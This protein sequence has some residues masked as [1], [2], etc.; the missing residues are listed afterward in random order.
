MAVGRRFSGK[1]PRLIGRVWNDVTRELEDFLKKLF[2]A[3]VGIPFGFMGTTP[4]TVEIEDSGSAGTQGSG[5]AAADHE[6][7][8]DIGTGTPNTV[9][10]WVTGPKL[11]D[12]LITDDGTVVT[13]NTTTTIRAA[14]LTDGSRGFFNVIGTL[15]SSPST[16][17]YGTRFII[18]PNATSSEVQ[19]GVGVTLNAG[20]TGSTEATIALAMG[21]AN[22]GTG[23]DY[24]NTANFAGL[25]QAVA[26][27]VGVNVG[28]S[29]RASGGSGNM[30]VQGIVNDDSECIGGMF[31]GRSSD[32]RSVG[33][34]AGLNSAIPDLSPLPNGAALIISNSDKAAPIIVARDNAN[35]VFEIDDG[36]NVRLDVTITPGGTTGNQTINKAAGSVNFA[37][38]AA[39]LT[40]TNNLI[41]AN[42]LIFLTLL[43]NDAT[44]V[45]G[46]VVAASGSCVIN[47]AVVPTAETKVGFLVINDA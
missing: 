39:T 4:T 14:A 42:S 2:D 8:V 5:W 31:L 27:T 28:L 3:Q 36:G 32:S 30:G 41:V 45:L 7:E 19:V 35:D 25:G 43:T 9:V 10:K 12:S 11:G 46:D 15:P 1:V 17:T 44:A 47:M 23:T 24:I 34:I 37:A 26:T 29:G 20:Y 38:G 40:L 21:T 33:V 13:A 6:H 16:T 22:A 18:T